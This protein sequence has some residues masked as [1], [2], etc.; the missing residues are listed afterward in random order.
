MTLRLSRNGKKEESSCFCI[1]HRSLKWTYFTFAYNPSLRALEKKKKKKKKK[2]GQFDDAFQAI[3]PR[4]GKVA[5]TRKYLDAAW[6]RPGNGLDEIYF[7]KNPQGEKRAKC[8]FAVSAPHRN[9]IRGLA[10]T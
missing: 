2:D 7:K 5:Y 4:N 10:F 1:V 8:C 6:K 9:G 3:A